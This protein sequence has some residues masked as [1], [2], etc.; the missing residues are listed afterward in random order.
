MIYAGIDIE[1]TG[2]EWAK[3]HRIVEI[4]ALVYRHPEPTPVIRFV[5]RV[6]PQRPIDA[7][8][9]A[10]HGISFDDLT[11]CPTWDAVA[12]KIIRVLQ[13]AN[14]VVAHNGDGF[15]RPFI[16]HELRRVGLPVPAATWIDTCK[17]ARWATPFGKSPSLGE[18]CFACGVEYDPTKAHAAAYDV[19]RMMLCFFE[20][21]RQGFY[22]QVADIPLTV[23][24]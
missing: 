9:Q 1:T 2:L 24:A 18:L 20:A 13:T 17:D 21:R 12:P 11:A 19:E 23:A 4:A 22:N 5:Q 14:V 3:D 15:D 16:E 10:V 6:N 7:K 8:A